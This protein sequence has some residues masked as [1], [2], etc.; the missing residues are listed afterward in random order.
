MLDATVGFDPAD[1]ITR[2]CQNPAFRAPSSGSVGDAGLGDVTIGI[3]RPLFGSAP[4]KTRKWR[5]SSAS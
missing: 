4:A 2:D 3:L 5:V 1:P